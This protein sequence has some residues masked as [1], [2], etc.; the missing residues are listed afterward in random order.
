VNL[1][2]CRIVFLSKICLARAVLLLK[3]QSEKIMWK[4]LSTLQEKESWT[5]G[6]STLLLFLFIYEKDFLLHFSKQGVRMKVPLTL[7]LTLLMTLM[8]CLHPR[9]CQ[10]KEDGLETVSDEELQKL[11]AQENHVI[12]LFSEFSSYIQLTTFLMPLIQ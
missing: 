6:R 5:S 3:R 1:W 11:I 4:G 10:S 7:R 9:W 2:I 12:V 8:V